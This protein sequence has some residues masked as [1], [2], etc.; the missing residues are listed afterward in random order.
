M[1]LLLALLVPAAGCGHDGE[2][3]SGPDEAPWMTI[4]AESF[5]EQVEARPPKSLKPRDESIVYVSAAPGLEEYERDLLLVQDA[6]SARQLPRGY[7]VEQL[8]PWLQGLPVGPIKWSLYLNEVT[9]DTPSRKSAAFT[10]TWFEMSWTRA[11]VSAR[12]E[13]SR[14]VADEPMDRSW[15]PQG[16]NH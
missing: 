6:V 1:L 9:E 14:W 13:G 2:V 10:L 12:R 15:L 5:L 8:D 3:A 11:E 7:Y 4:L 16:M